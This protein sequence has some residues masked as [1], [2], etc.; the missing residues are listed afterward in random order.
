VTTPRP[1]K[2]SAARKG[3][4]KAGLYRPSFI[5]IVLFVLLITLRKHGL[6]F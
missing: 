2:Y 5:A 4:K 6:L 1:W 3:A